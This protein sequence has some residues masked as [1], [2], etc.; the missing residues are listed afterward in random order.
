MSFTLIELLVVIAIISILASLLLPA[1]GKARESGRRA[2]CQSQLRQLSLG[3][4]MYS[5][6]D[7]QGLLPYDAVFSWWD[8]LWFKTIRGP[9]LSLPREFRPSIFTCPTLQKPT[10]D[11][12][13][14]WEQ[15]NY[16]INKEITGQPQYDPYPSRLMIGV[17][18]GPWRLDSLTNASDCVLLSDSGSEGPDFG[19]VGPIPHNVIDR[20]SGHNTNLVQ[21]MGIANF[22]VHGGGANLLFSD[23]HLAWLHK[24]DYLRSNGMVYVWPE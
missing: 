1:L 3:L 10:Y 13:W 12:P 19:A 18:W 9:Y 21:G 2:L 11:V 22:G 7:E 5:G 24:T 16:C 15:G 8:P 4:Y 6:D 23:G 14:Q 20:W 17:R